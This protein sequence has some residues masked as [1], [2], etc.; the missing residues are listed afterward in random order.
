MY[1]LYFHKL[2]LSKDFKNIPPKDREHIIKI[3]NKR[4]KKDPESYG[5]PL[6]KELKGYFRLRIDYYRVIYRIEKEKVTVFIV[7]IGLR[8]D[9][10][11]YIKSAKRLKLI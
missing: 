8:K 10:M 7:H 1:Q 4:L 9:L 5:K 2:V 6:R 11:A 3:I